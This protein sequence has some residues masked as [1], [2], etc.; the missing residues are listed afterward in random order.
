MTYRERREARAERLRGWAEKSQER[1][2]AALK[3]S[4][5]QPY[6]HDIAWLTQPGHIPG[7]TETF[8]REHRAYQSLDKAASMEAR[9]AGIE[10]QLDRAI[11]SDDP[12]AVERLEARVAELE[13]KRDTIKAANK[14]APRR[15]LYPHDGQTPEQM[16]ESDRIPAYALTNLT[17]EIARNRKRLEQL[18]KGPPVTWFHASR[19]DADVC[20]K[21]D[22]RRADHDLHPRSELLICPNPD[23]S[24]RVL[25]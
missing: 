21:C 13:A 25:N 2:D 16:A 24:K 11:Y 1:A 19:R 4:D 12:D 3:T 14:A 15:R 6:R 8:E 20:Y 5:A 23:G 9:A 22:F 17:A 10:A 7:R 18:R